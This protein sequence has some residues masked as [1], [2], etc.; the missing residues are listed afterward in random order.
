MTGGSQSQGSWGELV[1]TRIL[2]ENLKF[3]EGEEF[4]LHKSF[5][6]EDGRKIQ[7]SY[8]PMENIAER[9]VIKSFGMI[10]IQKMKG[11]GEA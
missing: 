11:Q 7:M 5:S 9:K 8:S 4:E 1:L 10:L 6:E 2:T 3:T